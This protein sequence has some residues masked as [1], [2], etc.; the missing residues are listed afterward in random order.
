MSMYSTKR[1]QLEL[2][3]EEDADDL[4]KIWKNYNITK[5]TMIKNTKEISDSKERIRRQLG[6]GKENALGPFTVRE[7]EKI[8]GYCGGRKNTNDEM[9]IFYHI[10]DEKW[11]NG[12]GTE[13]A[14]EL[15]RIAIFER[16]IKV[17]KAEA[18]IENV[19]SWRVLEK[20]GMKRIGIEKNAFEND[21]GK[22]DF[23]IYKMEKVDK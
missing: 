20:V 22:H 18:A 14:A 10:D 5:Y 11:G 4:L 17:I 3:K 13:I 8:I 19:A 15:I 7:R 2:V 9:E 16:N 1:L 23:C 6:W 12:Y 21:E